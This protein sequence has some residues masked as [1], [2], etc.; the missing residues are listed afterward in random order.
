[1]DTPFARGELLAGRYTITGEL[2]R[3]AGGITYRGRDE[4]LGG[5]VAIKVLVLGGGDG[6]KSVELFDREARVLRGLRHP[7]I[8]PYVDSFEAPSAA[9]H[10]YVLVR[11][12]AQGSTLAEW[13]EGGARL[14]ESDVA[15]LGAQLLAIVVFLQEL[16][17]PL[18]HR[19]IKPQNVVLGPDLV[20]RLIDFGGVRDRFF[21]SMAG[22][23]TMVGSFGYMAPEQSS[24]DATLASD[25]YGVAATMVFLLTHVQPSELPRRR[26]KIDFR[27]RA[28]C[29]DGLGA[30]LDR[31]LEPVP[32]DRFPDAT[33]AFA[34][35]QAVRAP[36]AEAP[37]AARPLPYPPGF[38][39]Q[40]TPPQRSAR[41]G[42]AP[43]EGWGGGLVGFGLCASV[44][45]PLLIIGGGLLHE[46]MMDGA[47]RRE[48]AARMG[49]TT[50][51]WQQARREIVARAAEEECAS[52]RRAVL[53]SNLRALIPPAPPDAS[54]SD[55]SV[56]LATLLHEH[57]VR[58][59]AFV[60]SE[61][62]L[63]VATLDSEGVVRLWDPAAE[64]VIA[65]VGSAP[66]S[67]LSAPSAGEELLLGAAK[68][69][70]VFSP[71]ERALR[72][73]PFRPDA[74]LDAIALDGAGAGDGSLAAVHMNGELRLLEGH[75][76]PGA[77]R[78]PDAVRGLWVA[79][80]A[81]L[82]VV[83]GV[84]T[85]HVLDL[86]TLERR[87][88][89]RCT[90]AAVSASRVVLASD[91]AVSAWTPGGGVRHI[92]KVTAVSSLATDSAGH[93]VAIGDGYG[94]LQ[95]VDSTPVALGRVAILLGRGRAFS[96]AVKQVALS[97]DGALVA[98]SDG[99]QIVKIGVVPGRASRLA[100]MPGVLHRA[101]HRAW[102]ADV[103][104]QP[105]W[106]PLHLAAF[107][108]ERGAVQALLDTGAEVD[109]PSAVGRTPLY[110]AAKAGHLD[111]VRMLFERGAKI[112][113]LAEFGFRPLFPAAQMGHE[114][115]VAY[116][117][118]KGASVHSRIDDG[119]NAVHVAA[120]GGAD[121][122][123]RLL[124][125]AGAQ[126]DAAADSGMT[127]LAEACRRGR[128][129]TAKI[130]IEEGHVDPG[131]PLPRLGLSPAL[132]AVF[133][134]QPGV[135]DVLLRHGVKTAPV[136][137][138]G[139]TLL[140]LATALGHAESAAVLRAHAG[141]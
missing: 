58:Q 125:A 126:A 31:A 90:H 46:K 138:D 104:T 68:E 65:R 62:A 95:I 3:G 97:P 127:P 88:S 60:G 81:R 100:S 109:A 12:L 99:G 80:D 54:P 21:R 79:R 70:Q 77:L 47:S 69:M 135:L 26:L 84:D 33:T 49:K 141:R 14:T 114:D 105:G 2:G 20:A 32:E 139:M 107:T 124:L 106:T 67:R 136:A 82:L 15:A 59:V 72:T 40:V 116:L 121:A 101:G 76:Q 71:R 83:Q 132:I 110:Q 48:A 129:S 61:P 5:E 18:V 34:S 86:P 7:G 118:E 56:P 51:Q 55:L 1:M 137:Y 128:A 25:V 93:L 36:R 27:A 122:A 41:A 50:E 45:V 89:M 57:P 131:A 112:D 117:L 11:Q 74:T 35:L 108:G 8:P 42:R 115:V 13:V 133:H 16:S 92:A 22:G 29:S 24:G 98:S 43:G 91:G 63:T 119:A 123:L 44:L 52:A 78:W 38:P 102:D 39:P 103:G 94:D 6:W 64:R 96:G 17:P 28:R 19:D 10:C 75:K 85:L 140:E 37:R 30:W 120:M 53:R 130:L 9:G 23:I 111:V 134:D 113:A 4:Q 87:A 66:V 73:L